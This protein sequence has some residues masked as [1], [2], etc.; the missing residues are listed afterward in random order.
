MK[1]LLIGGGGR[2]HALAWKLCRDDPG[3][4]L[5]V[6]PGNPGMDTLGRCVPIGVDKLKDLVNL[7]DGE[8]IDLTIV[9]PESPLEA[10]I[11][12]LFQTHGLPVFGPTREAARIETSK[13]F[14]KELMVR[15][16]IPTARASQHSDAREAKA[17]LANFGTPVV[18]KASGL[19]GGKGVIVAQ[20]TA[21]AERAIDA[22]LGDRIFG[23]AGREIL[24][25]EFMEG[26]EL[27][28]F[29]ITDGHQAIP[30]LAAQD[31][32]RLLE[33][34]FGPNTGGMG[35]YAPTSV[36]TPELVSRVMTE[37]VRPTLSAMRDAASP[38]KGLLYVGLML[39]D[40]G[41]KV[42]EFNCRFG[43][44][45]TQALM[46]LMDSSLLELVAAVVGN[47]SLSRARYPQWKPL[48]AVTT[49][50]AA[51]GYPHKVRTGDVI[52]LPPPEQG[53]EVFHA[54]TARDPLTGELVT[55]GGRVLAVTAVASSLIEA[56]E[57]SR[58]HAEQVSFSG[59]QLRRDIGWRE[60]TRDA[61]VT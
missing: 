24:I 35:A 6:A 15:A 1:V 11:V 23:A 59:K 32:K 36:A 21:E 42:V 25:E 38:F 13:R 4:E 2:E 39:T 47:G 61:R 30:L 7:A 8:Q 17:A 33:G 18:I 37:I 52:H 45:E 34:D 19:A 16:R 60:L 51:A 14:A 28:L 53:V 49:V 48:C 44:P 29:A 46:P 12:N 57:L 26:E 31:H 40:D 9:G 5:F 43:D 41:P 20:S 22:M 56:T 58:S 55:A 3:I 27:S 50:V 10:G 54:G